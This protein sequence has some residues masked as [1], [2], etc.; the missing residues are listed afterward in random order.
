MSRSISISSRFSGF[1]HRVFVVIFD[2]SLYFCGTSGD[3]LFMV[4][5]CIYLSLLCFSFLLVWLAVYFVNY[6]SKD[7]LPD[8]LIF[9]LKVVFGVS[10]SFSSA[11]ILVIS[12]LLLAFGFF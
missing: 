6:F 7:Q 9:F 5:Y 2:G 8:L 11:L 10:I 12:C 1:V 3:I 4:F